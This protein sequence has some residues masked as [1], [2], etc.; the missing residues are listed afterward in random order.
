MVTDRRARRVGDLVTI[1]LVERTSAS[2]SAS[3]D[4][5]RE[6]DN[7]F[8]LPDSSRSAGCRSRRCRPAATRASRGLVAPSSATS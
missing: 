3:A 8:R 6:S 2:K 1:R 7:S 4:S 5:A